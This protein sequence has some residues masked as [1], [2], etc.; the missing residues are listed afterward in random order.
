MPVATPEARVA[1]EALERTRRR[2][3]GRYP[4]RRQWRCGKCH[5]TGN[6]IPIYRLR[7]LLEHMPAVTDCS[8]DY[9][10]YV[11]LCEPCWFVAFPARSGSWAFSRNL[12]ADVSH[13]VE[14]AEL[15][16][17]PSK[18]RATT[19]GT[20]M[21]HNAYECEIRRKGIAVKYLDNFLDYQKLKM[22]FGSED[23]EFVGLATSSAVQEFE[24]FCALHHLNV[25]S[26][27]WQA[28][29]KQSGADGQTLGVLILC[30]QCSTGDF[31]GI[32]QDQALVLVAVGIGDIETEDG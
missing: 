31:V 13:S 3:P 4:E 5:A 14:L 1:L 25:S 18:G 16:N 12:D 15:Q 28:I 26:D 8:I 22:H 32:D 20:E 11:Y 29:E 27:L 30:A 6:E 7:P 24:D 10:G 2:L 23:D 21:S 17:Q 9:E 19:K